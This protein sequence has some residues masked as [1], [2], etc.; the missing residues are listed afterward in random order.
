M[1]NGLKILIE[2]MREFPQDFESAYTW[3]RLL[4]EARELCIRGDFSEED[5]REFMQA[6]KQLNIT[7]FE[8]RVVNALVP[9]DEVI[10][11]EGQERM[12]ISSNG[13]LGI[14]TQPSSM[15][16]R[17]ATVNPNIQLGA[18]QLSES[19]IKTIKKQ[20]GLK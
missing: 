4:D 9:R 5:A 2:R 18:T 7:M 6:S 19:D 17:N 11:W 10:Q 20:A 3:T 1:N 12:R 16:F 14:G 15:Y 13:S 8:A